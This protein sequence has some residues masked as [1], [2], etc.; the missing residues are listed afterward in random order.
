MRLIRCNRCGV[1]HETP[2]PAP[3][4][5]FPLVSPVAMPAWSKVIIAQT[6][7]V[8]GAR[9]PSERY[10]LCEDCREVFLLQFMVGATVAPI[11]KAAALTPL[12][13]D[14]MTDCQLVWN[15]GKGELLCYH[16]D[17]ELYHALILDNAQNVVDKT[18]WVTCTHGIPCGCTSAEGLDNNQA[19]CTCPCHLAFG[20]LAGTGNA[21]TRKV[22]QIHFRDV[23]HVR[24]PPP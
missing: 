11:T 3:H 16:D 12:P 5:V 8:E 17:P 10:D 15:P 1:E 9:G 22:R 7:S 19:K 18:G 6:P 23:L 13:H 4:Q 2:M 21:L 20:H 14:P 24:F